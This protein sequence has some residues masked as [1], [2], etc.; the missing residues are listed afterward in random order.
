MKLTI[1]E[2]SERL[3]SGLNDTVQGFI[4][5]MRPVNVPV[6]GDMLYLMSNILNVVLQDCN[7]SNDE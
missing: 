4:Q 5:V 3:L 2:E 1:S 6:T 7:A